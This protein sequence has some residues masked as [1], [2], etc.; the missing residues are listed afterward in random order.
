MSTRV[1]DL[2]SNDALSIVKGHHLVTGSALLDLVSDDWLRVLVTRC[3]ETAALV[4]FPLIYDGTMSCEPAESDDEHMLR[5]FNEHQQ[6]DKG[7]GPAL[8]PQAA[9]RAVKTLTEAGYQT[10]CDRSDWVL[11][12]AAEAVQRHLIEGWS[13]AALLI[14]PEH[15]DWVAEWLA[16]RLRHLAA[17][18]S[19][20]IVGHLD[21]A[22]FPLGQI[23]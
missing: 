15:A 10:L 20:L 5:F 8:G 3:R 4:L 6:T 9:P 21:V 1:A 14:K 11:T 2:T 7:F 13:E 22:A 16:R 12:P 19:R 17:G 18:R 23:G